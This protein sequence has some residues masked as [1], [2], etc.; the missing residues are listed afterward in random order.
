MYTGPEREINGRF[1]CRPTLQLV[2]AFW[3][4][5]TSVLAT[6]NDNYPCSKDETLS[7]GM[8][9]KKIPWIRAC[10]CQ[11]KQPLRLVCNGPVAQSTSPISQQCLLACASPGLS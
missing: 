11:Q 7:M 9:R 1:A 4:R 3:G 8:E 5:G 2:K 10:R 6:G